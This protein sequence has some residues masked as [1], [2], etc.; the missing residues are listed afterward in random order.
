MV[1]YIPKASLRSHGQS[2]INSYHKLRK[3]NSC[4]R[5]AFSYQGPC[6]WNSI[7]L[8]IRHVKVIE[9]LNR[10]LEHFY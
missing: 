3:W 9:I 1:T 5:R 10:T 7:L 2:L 8:Y 4:D 6:V